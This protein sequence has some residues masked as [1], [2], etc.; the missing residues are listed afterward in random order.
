MAERGQESEWIL[1]YQSRLI[2]NAPRIWNY[3]LSL[4]LL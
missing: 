3:H 4:L 2:G 1:S